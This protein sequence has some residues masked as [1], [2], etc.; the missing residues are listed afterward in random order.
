[1]FN[2]A[3]Y[4]SWTDLFPGQTLTPTSNPSNSRVGQ[5]SIGSIVPS[6]VNCYFN[7]G[8][9]CNGTGAGNCLNCATGFGIY[10][11]TC[12]AL[13]P[14]LYYFRSPP[15]NITSGISLN[16]SA[17]NLSSPAITIAFFL[18]VY[19]FI[20]NSPMDYSIVNFDSVIA[21]MIVIY[22]FSFELNTQQY[23]IYQHS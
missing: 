11:N 2:Y 14:T 8:G 20:N 6:P 5:V 4:Y 13:N 10:G 15:N 23:L 19:A 21:I 3:S 9:I 22:L 16:L 12:K 1:M 18:K 17:L 7:C